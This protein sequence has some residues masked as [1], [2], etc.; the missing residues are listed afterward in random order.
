VHLATGPLRL[1]LIAVFGLAGVALVW[2]WAAR[3]GLLPALVRRA[4]R[5]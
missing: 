5:G 3:L 4:F 2:R 1:G